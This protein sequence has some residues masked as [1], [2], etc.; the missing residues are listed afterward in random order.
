MLTYTDE[1]KML[2]EKL[3]ARQ[4]AETDNVQMIEVAED[5]KEPTKDTTKGYAGVTLGSNHITLTHSGVYR[6]QAEHKT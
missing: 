6:T 4:D 5:V 2:D 1:M 3:K